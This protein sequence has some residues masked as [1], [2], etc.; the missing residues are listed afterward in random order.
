MKYFLPFLLLLL[1]LGCTTINEQNKPT[2]TLAK[3]AFQLNGEF[4]KEYT[5]K[6]YLNKIIENSLYVI[7][8]SEVVN[9]QFQFNGK[10]DYPERFA[11]TF[12][13]YSAIVVLIVE[14]IEYHL[15]INPDEIHNL[16]IEGSPLNTQLENYKDGAKTIFK[17][18]DY[19]YPAFQK[20]RLENDAEKLKAI[21]QKM[22][23]IYMQFN[24]Y[25]YN[26]IK[27][28]KD[29]YV[30]VMLLRD[31]LKTDTVDSTKIKNYY[32]LFPNN[33]KESPDGKL[34]EEFISSF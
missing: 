21:Q 2:E 5:T 19:L 11:L 25:T 9:N 6:V 24:A 7:D 33:L 26:F 32:N 23:S 22:D 29:S 1:S 10:V 4:T 28:N 12:E 20:A 15:L 34:I 13:Y 3:D 16:K 30:S 8:S 27:K 18:I 17:Q 31:M 14:N